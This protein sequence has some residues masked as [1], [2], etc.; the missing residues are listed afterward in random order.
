MDIVPYCILFSLYSLFVHSK[1][2][3][4]FHFPYISYFWKSFSDSF[5]FSRYTV[6]YIFILWL[7]S[8]LPLAFFLHFRN[9]TVHFALSLEWM[10]NALFS[11]VQKSSWKYPL[12][13]FCQAFVEDVVYLNAVVLL[14]ERLQ[15]YE[16]FL[17]VQRYCFSSLVLQKHFKWVQP[18]TTFPLSVQ[19]FFILS[20]WLESLHFF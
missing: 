6:K 16:L 12:L 1:C 3:H 14:S 13:Q 20:L 8:V 11:K 15:L 7:D 5:K 9:I 18:L 17:C 2:S 4:C 19:T 10:K